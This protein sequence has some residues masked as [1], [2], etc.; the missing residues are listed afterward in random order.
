VSERQPYSRIYWSIID[1]PKFATVYDDDKRLATWLRLL[2]V[3]DQAHPASPSI[4]FGTDK[5]ALAHLTEVGLVVLG[6]GFRFRIKGLDAER[7]RRRPPNAGPPPEPDPFPSDPGPGPDRD[8]VG[9]ESVDEQS[10]DEQSKDETRTAR[11][12]DPADAYWSLTGKYPNGGALSWIDDMS[13]S[14]GPESVVKAIAKAHLQ[15]KS[16]ATLLGRAQDLLRSEAR[17]LDKQSQA[18]VR[19]R[20]EEKRAAPRQVVDQEAVNAEIR[21]LMEIAA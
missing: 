5:K 19:Q 13:S 17:A 16:A 1:D 9:T 14:Y 12:P 15:D 10:R 2:I 7:I 18:E 4:P 3:A 11:A 8:G 6:T 20:I 21:K